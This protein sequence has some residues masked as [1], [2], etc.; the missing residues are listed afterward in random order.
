MNVSVERLRVWLLV[1]AGV[2]ALVVAGFLGYAHYRAHRFLA[3]LPAK[4]GVDI[5][6]ETNAFTYSQS[7]Q[8]KTI[9]T[10]HAAKAVQRNDGKVTLHDVGIVLYGR[11]TDRADRIY[12]SEFEYDQNAGV[13]RAMGLVHIDLEAPAP[14]DSRGKVAYASGQSE[15]G[16]DGKEHGAN[17]HSGD[18]ERLI[19]VKTSGLVFLQKLGVAATDE[20][21]EFEF[22]GLTGHAVGADFSSDT[23]LLTLH[24][25]V[26]VHGIEQGQPVVLTAAR[27]ELNRQTEL[28]TLT[29]VRYEVVGGAEQGRLA[30][31]DHA[32]IHLRSDGSVERMEGDGSV[33]LATGDGSTVTASRG[34]LTLNAS[35]QMQ[36]MVLL[37]G[38]HLAGN[39]AMRQTRGET[40]EG[41]ATF[42]KSGRLER[43]ILNGGVHLHTRERSGAGVD[44]WNE[45]DLT[46]KTVD[47]ALSAVDERHVVMREAT[48]TGEAKLVVVSAPLAG[49]KSGSAKGASSVLSGDVLTADFH[50]GDGGSELQTVHGAGHTTVVRVSET[51]AE[52]T[53]VGDTLEARFVSRTRQGSVVTSGLHAAGTKGTG[54][55]SAVEHSTEIATAVQAGHVVVT[56]RPVAKAGSQRVG[57]QHVEQQR[58][59]LQR[60]VADRAEYEQQSDEVTLTGAVQVSDGGNV[61]WADRVVLEQQS[62]DAVAVGSVKASY[63]AEQSASTN[64]AEPAVEEP[65]HVLASRAEMKHGAGTATFYGADGRL[66]R[67]W[68]GASQVEAPVLIF[69]QQARHLLAR[70]G[71][72]GAAMAV[73]AVFVSGGGDKTK[74]ASVVRVASRELNYSDVTRQADFTGGVMVNSA[75]GAMR[76]QSVTVYLRA[77]GGVGTVQMD[78]LGSKTVGQPSF[79]GGSVERVEAHGGVEL[80]QPGRRVTGEQVV[81]TALDGMF[82][83][84]GTRG[85]PPKMV[86]AVRGTITGAALRFHA[87]D[88]SVMVLHGTGEDAG[89]RVR[90]ETRVKQ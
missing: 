40:E 52:Q 57:Q 44:A 22:K 85:A 46:G 49:R 45:R 67:L 24:S 36:S 78:P 39:Q 68:Q 89:Q 21:L 90:T 82:V 29:Q 20:A 56:N 35:G 7:V 23:G 71:G 53:S 2:L 62:G 41:R 27:A 54:G 63:V 73:H 12:G 3:G 61:V 77:A 37:G 16:A 34:D 64:G 19:H 48:A 25:A 38:V 59:G 6:R 86:D 51:G 58:P 69:E 70:G 8:G 74:K 42:D 55:K 43:V 33:V 5:Q 9:Y 14:V 79:M 13:I 50:V 4:L 15:F 84:T 72:Q 30:E 47:M 81:Y 75:D 10:I 60:A 31:M 11:K 83:M 88:N 32:T 26:S 80:T 28:A 66:A 87:G 1:G 65:V 76:G 17:V 18:D